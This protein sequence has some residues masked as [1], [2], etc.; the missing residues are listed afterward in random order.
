MRDLE[1]EAVIG[2]HL[3]EKRARQPIRINIDLAVSEGPSPIADDLNDEV[4]YES[5]V[6]GVKALVATGHV[7]LVETL[8]ERIAAQCLQ[9]S[10]VR[11]ARIRVEKLK[12]IAEARSV[13]IEI[14]RVRTGI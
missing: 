12:A 13:G 8:A 14:E 2:I 4:C 3:Y 6:E 10:R 1:L 9:D 11:M 7:N 5:I